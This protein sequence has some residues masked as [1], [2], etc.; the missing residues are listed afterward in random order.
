MN[1]PSSFLKE[2]KRHP[3]RFYIIHYSSEGLYDGTGLSP[4]ITS[5]V[6]MHYSTRQ[7]L[8][9]ATHAISEELGIER[10]KIPENQDLIEAKLLKRF[11]D[12][13]R[14]RRHCYWV[15]WNMRNLTFGFEHLEHRYHVLTK[16][17]CHGTAVETRINLNDVLN[18]RFGLNYAQPPKM[19]NLM[20]MNGSLDPRFLEGAA[21]ADA[22]RAGDYI[23]MNSSTMSKVEFYA[24]VIKLLSKGRLR[25]QAYGLLVTID[26]LLDSRTSRIVA[27]LGALF[28]FPATVYQI[29]LWL[30]EKY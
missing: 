28:G 12:F 5:I 29:F 21:E 16:D 19:K 13:V 1:T 7:T 27:A 20:L 3:E 15:H 2:I 10:T 11:F 4:R 24:H 30:S 17:N 8:S 6:V 25:T 14:E 23:R 9:F 26:R 18:E 22:F